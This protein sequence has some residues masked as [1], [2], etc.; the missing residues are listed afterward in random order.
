[1]A[2]AAGASEFAGHGPQVAFAV[3]ATA[4]EYVPA[5]QLRHVPAPAT[6]LYFPATHA[7]H[8][9]GPPAVLYV[10][11]G[12]GAHVVPL[13]SVNPALHAQAFGAALPAG[14]SASAGQLS[15]QST[16]FS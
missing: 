4:L 10:P 9:C 13:I 12:H 5:R 8:A 7:V 11:A 6:A 2:L 3:A 14:E 15:Q 16:L 1:M